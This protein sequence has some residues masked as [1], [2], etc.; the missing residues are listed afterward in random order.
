MCSPTCDLLVSLM[1]PPTS[2]SMASAKAC[3]TCSRALGSKHA[4]HLFSI[5]ALHL[6]LAIDTLQL[7]YSRVDTGTTDSA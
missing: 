3:I 1:M 5:H 2:P 6:K 4:L 7:L